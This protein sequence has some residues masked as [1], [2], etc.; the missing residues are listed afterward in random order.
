MRF[1]TKERIIWVLI[2]VSLLGNAWS[3]YWQITATKA[4]NNM[5]MLVS[6]HEAAWTVLL[7]AMDENNRNQFIEAAKK[8][9]NGNVVQ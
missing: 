7:S 8:V 6:S 5:T 1:I 2:A 9:Q 4:I 3:I